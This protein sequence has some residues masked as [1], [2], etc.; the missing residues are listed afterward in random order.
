MISD[1]SE[2]KVEIREITKLIEEANYV[3]TVSERR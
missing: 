3:Y 1:I 2:I